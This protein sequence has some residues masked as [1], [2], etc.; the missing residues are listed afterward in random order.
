MS[1][2]RF[3]Y[4][5]QS[6][7]GSISG[8]LLLGQSVECSGLVSLRP[9]VRP[10]SPSSTALPQWLHGYRPCACCGW[11]LVAGSLA[12]WRRQGDSSLALAV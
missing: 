12:S 5:H 8:R 6:P 2:L 11:Q 7:N 9:A 10:P 1:S 4:P 3:A